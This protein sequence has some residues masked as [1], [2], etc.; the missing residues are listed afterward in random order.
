MY[1]KTLR[2]RNFQ[3]MDIVCSKLGS[4]LLLVTFTG[5]TN[6]LVWRNTL[7]WTKT[8]ALTNTL[9]YYGIRKLRIFHAL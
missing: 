9:A 7:A 3:K 8:L 6:T 2:T 1:Y 4:F 5:L